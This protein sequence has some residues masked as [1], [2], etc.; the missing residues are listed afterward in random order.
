MPAPGRARRADHEDPA[1]QQVPVPPRR[2]G[3][4]HARSRGE[5]AEAGHEVELLR[6][7]LSR[8]R[9]GPVRR[10]FFVPTR[11]RA[12]PALVP[13]ETSG[14]GTDSVLEVSGT[15][16]VGCPRPRSDPSSSTCTTSITSSLCRS[17]DPSAPPGSLRVMTLHDFKLACPT[18]R[19]L[20][21][22]R[23]CEACLPRRFWS[24]TRRSCH[25]GSLV[26]CTLNGLELA[27]HTALGIYAPVDRFLCPSRFLERKMRRD[28]CIR[29]A[30][31]GS[32][33][34]WTSRDPAEASPGRACRLCGRSLGREGRRRTS[35]GG[36]APTSAPPRRRRRRPGPPALQ[37]LAEAVAPKPPVPRTASRRRAAGSS[38]PPPSASSRPAATRTRRWR[39][40]RHS[41]PAS[42]SWTGPRWHPRTGSTLGV[43]GCWSRPATPTP[44]ARRVSL[45]RGSVPRVRDGSRGPRQSRARIHF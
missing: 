9:A 44:S 13:G 16:F 15:R 30:S 14:G 24:T 3:E 25:E 28:A 33:T 29:I 12:Q 31:D 2:C 7:E 19:F 22:G 4:L 18:H 26:A 40:S 8:E 35:R 17:L 23:V 1:R 10:W 20:A 6:D 45:C 37:R 5:T 21:H 39:S 41:R 34:S 36:R 32:R 38:G 43:T 27:I 42:R 11:L